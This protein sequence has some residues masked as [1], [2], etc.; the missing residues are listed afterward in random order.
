MSSNVVRLSLLQNVRFAADFQ[1]DAPDA[2]TKWHA[3]AGPTFTA[4]LPGHRLISTTDPIIL[5]EVLTSNVA[6]F[7]KGRFADDL[8]PF[9]GR[10]TV[11]ISDGADWAR[12]R[13]ICAGFFARARNRDFEQAV[14]RRLEPMLKRLREAA[15]SGT[16][17]QLYYP[18]RD[19]CFRAVCDVWFGGVPERELDDVAGLLRAGTDIAARRMLQLV[20]LP[21]WWPV[22]ANARYRK[23][24]AR[25]HRLG[26]RMIA[27]ARGGPS[28]HL[29]GCFANSVGADP[30]RALS[31]VEARNNVFM[32]F[33]ACYE[34]PT[35][36]WLLFELA[37][38]PE[39]RGKAVREVRQ[40]SGASEAGA[41][42]DLPYLQG[43]IKETFRLRPPA[44]LMGRRVL[45]AVEAGGVALEPGQTLVVPVK[46]V[47][48]DP[49][50]WEQPD[51]F[52][53]DRFVAPHASLDYLAFGAGPRGCIGQSMAIAVMQK[54]VAGILSEFDFETVVSEAPPMHDK[55]K[56]YPRGGVPVR[57]TRH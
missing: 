24:A 9:W 50:R 57:V 43:C 31:P 40:Q 46:S 54:V 56:S 14:E 26:E 45:R 13:R 19:V 2:F 10:S 15:K 22:G 35:L 51:L 18:V 55:L 28:D 6:P 48:R 47:Q 11:Q 39:I 53:P 34:W 38:R 23:I 27:Q 36:G 16:P 25:A 17:T 32:L 42:S 7:G 8:S 37:S 29:L 3:V 33:V 49:R 1:R 12:Q 20:S 44:P 30:E 21:L 4:K 52:S 41:S 5:R